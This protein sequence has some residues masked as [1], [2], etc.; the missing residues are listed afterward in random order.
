MRRHIPRFQPP[1]LTAN[2]ALAM[3]VGELAKKKGCTPA[4]LAIGWIVA[5]GRLRKGMP[6]I[7]PIPGTSS[8]ERV[9]E[10]A[11]LIEL[12][13]S[14]LKE[15]DDMLENF[16]P[17]GDRYPPQGMEL[18]DEDDDELLVPEG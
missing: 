3:A 7:I 4:Q 17:V 14:G 13:E 15:I 5:L 18:L 9:L 8:P 1:H 11:R 2:L 6:T 12:D 10:N 16:T